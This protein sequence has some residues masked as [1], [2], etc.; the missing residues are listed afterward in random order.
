MVCEIYFQFMALLWFIQ[1][2]WI[3]DKIKV[4]ATEATDNWKLLR[5]FDSKAGLPGGLLSMVGVV[6]WRPDSTGFAAGT[7]GGEV[8]AHAALWSV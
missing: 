6:T 8:H 1:C 4:W 7:I 5:T 2:N 3:Q